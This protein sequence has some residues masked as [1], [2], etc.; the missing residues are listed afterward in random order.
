MS[1]APA[2][3]PATTLPATLPDGNVPVRV[4][5]LDASVQAKAYELAKSIDIRDS[6]AILTFGS[7][8]QHK[9]SGIA[10]Q[11][12]GTVRVKDAGDVGEAL[13]D[14]VGKIRG[15]GVKDIAAPGAN[16]FSKLFN[17]IAAFIARYE[18]LE[19]QIDKIVQT[20]QGSKINMM[21]DVASLDELYNKNV[22]FVHDLEVF[23][24]AGEIKLATL[25]SKDLEDL[26]ARFA[27]TNDPMDA[28]AVNDFQAAI[29]RF[30]KKLHDLRLVRY[31]GIQTAPQ[32]RTIQNNDSG[33]L[34]KVTTAVNTTIPL[35]KRQAALLI[36]AFDT[37]KVAEI[38]NDVDD[39]TNQL[40]G[41]GAGQIRQIN[42]EAAKA[43]QR[44]IVEI[45][46]LK[47]ADD[48]IIAMLEDTMRI[49]E[50]G[51]AMRVQA[52][53]DLAAMEVQLKAKIATLGSK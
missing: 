47:K 53:K 36:A 31:I 10:E 5:D 33:L 29:D 35:W 38:S 11:M 45:S 6:T 23:I 32:I 26:K 19:T 15:V 14:L 20:L 1:D 51:R 24:A 34:E 42:A 27:K 7:A 50:E 37:K 3:N 9:V 40:I 4:E 22:E 49:R 21:R 13:T 48:D 30:E 41:Q 39:M 44:G 25:R 16:I 8:A 18:K 43:N 17:G 2:G 46:N 52:E 12:M 28:Q